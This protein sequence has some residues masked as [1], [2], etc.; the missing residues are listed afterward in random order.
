M[1]ERSEFWHSQPGSMSSA[2]ILLLFIRSFQ[3]LR[4]HGSLMSVA[5]ISTGN[6]CKDASQWLANLPITQKLT[7]TLVCDP[8]LCFEVSE[9]WHC[10]W[11]STWGHWL[12][13]RKIFSKG[14]E[15][16]SHES[17]ICK[18]RMPVYYFPKGKK[19]FPVRQAQEMTFE[20]RTIEHLRLQTIY[21]RIAFLNCHCDTKEWWPE[22]LRAF[23]NV[24]H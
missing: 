19:K 12:I 9:I 15:W 4:G 20:I 18:T 17:L 11:N 16:L 8:N 22:R 14:G 21:L 10:S 5:E 13:Y 7:V 1:F 6:H 24:L 23:I 3:N 2:W